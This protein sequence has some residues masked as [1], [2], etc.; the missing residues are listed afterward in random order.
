ML[1][2]YFLQVISSADALLGDTTRLPRAHSIRGVAASVSFLRNWSVSRVLEAATWSLNPIFAS[3]YL[4][5]LSC[6]L[7]NCSSLG[8]FV[9]AG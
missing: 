2:S 8:P 7:D 6:I 4:K 5:D 9:T 1:L 3:F